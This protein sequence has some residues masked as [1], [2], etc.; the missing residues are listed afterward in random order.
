MGGRE[1]VVD[2]R[3]VRDGVMSGNAEGVEHEIEP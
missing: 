1:E 3:I 2:V